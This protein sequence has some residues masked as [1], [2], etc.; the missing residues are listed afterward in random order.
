MATEAQIEEIISI[1]SVGRPLAIGLLNAAGNNTELALNRYFDQ[2][3]AA[4]EPSWSENAFAADRYGQQDTS[5]IPSI[6]IEY[7][8]GLNQYP[9]SNAGSVGPTRPPSRVSNHAEASQSGEIPMQ[10]IETGQESGVMGR[11]QPAFGPANRHDYDPNHWAMV[12]ISVADSV[13]DAAAGNRKR[14]ENGPA[15]IKPLPS[16]N[17]LPALITIAQTIPQLRNQLLAREIV[18]DNYKTKEDWWKTGTPNES[19][20]MEL[21]SEEQSQNVEFLYELQR[22][23][24][25]LHGTRRA[26]GS[27]GTSQETI[28]SSVAKPLDE[29]DELGNFFLHWSAVYQKKTGNPLNGVARSQIESEPSEPGEETKKTVCYSFSLT[30]DTEFPSS[31]TLYDVLDNVFYPAENDAYP[32]HFQKVSNVLLLKLTNSQ[33]DELHCKIPAVL[34]VDA[35]LQE[36]A[37][38]MQQN[39]QMMKQYKSELDLIDQKIQ[40]KK[41]HKMSSTGTTVDSLTLL[42]TSMLAFKPKNDGSEEDTKNAATLAKLQRCYRSVEEQLK[43]LEDQKQQI[44]STLDQMAARCRPPLEEE[45]DSPD[46]QMQGAAETE[47]TQPKE[48]HKFVHSHYL[49]GLSTRPGVYY[50]RPAPNDERRDWWRIEYSTAGGSE[51]YV[52]R[53]RLPLGA[54]LDKVSTEYKSALL[55]YANNEALLEP[56]TPL[57]EPLREFVEADNA[58]FMEEL[59]GWQWSANDDAN[60]EPLIGWGP[61]PPCNTAQ[62]PGTTSTATQW[63]HWGP[64][65]ALSTVLEGDWAEADVSVKGIGG[66][67]RM[68]R[69]EHMDTNMDTASDESVTLTPVSEVSETESLLDMAADATEEE[70]IR[71]N[72]GGRASSPLHENEKGKA[73]PRDAGRR[74]S[75]P[76]IPGFDGA[77]ESEKGEEKGGED[78]EMEDMDVRIVGTDNDAPSRESLSPMSSLGKRMRNQEIEEGETSNEKRR[79]STP[80]DHLSR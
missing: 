53:D 54:V 67:P 77:K 41:Y 40:K 62:T 13:P 78:V 30:C 43:Q 31:Q 79:A 57:P 73:T 24:A 29:N 21:G 37:P 72:A 56:E 46:L 9:H 71:S 63:D 27:V 75:S 44:R 50:L 26:Y 6:N 14:E 36:K 59:R 39:F 16:E 74:G 35:Y 19:G 52:L 47:E 42:E 68:A 65:A 18:H 20:S 45:S 48:R 1:L 28:L 7:P 70:P 66:L 51:A 58:R 2:G 17:Y 10:S 22:L 4:A 69:G 61:L 25:F 60:I 38:A 34:H 33:S 3:D 15:I 12:P 32:A 11:T 49:A 80:S 55:V 5:G 23:M 64:D 76:T 8:P